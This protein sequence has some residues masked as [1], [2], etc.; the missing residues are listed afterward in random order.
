MR[1]KLKIE[2]ICADYSDSKRHVFDVHGDG[3][4]YDCHNTCIVWKRV[5]FFGLPF[6]L[7]DDRMAPIYEG[8]YREAVKIAEMLG[9][10]ILCQQLEDDGEDPLVICDDIDEELGYVI[11]ALSDEEDGPLSLENGDPYQNVYYIHELAMEEGYGDQHLAARIINE[12]PGLVLTFCHVVPDILAFYPASADLV[13]DGEDEAIEQE[14]PG[15][16]PRTTIEYHPI[17]GQQLRMDKRDGAD[18]RPAGTSDFA[19]SAYSIDYEVFEKVGFK[20]MG[21]SGVLYKYVRD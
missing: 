11:S 20:E 7:Q 3:R 14:G 13:P 8:D 10:L 6:D 15:P 1:K 2:S 5:T 19:G 9:C 12:L 18:I 4:A 17:F 21:D 16:V